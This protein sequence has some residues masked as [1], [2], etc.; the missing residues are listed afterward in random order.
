[1]KKINCL[2]ISRVVKFR[3]VVV[4]SCIIEKWGQKLHEGKWKLVFLIHI[5]LPGKTRKYF[6][7]VLTTNWWDGILL[8]AF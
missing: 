5:E 2:S 7:Y 4:V 8:D 6:E 1:M 3:P